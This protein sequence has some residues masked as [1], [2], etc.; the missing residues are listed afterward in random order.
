MADGKRKAAMSSSYTKEG[1]HIPIDE[2]RDIISNVIYGIPG[3][4][5]KYTKSVSPVAEHRLVKDGQGKHLPIY[6]LDKP[7]IRDINRM[8]RYYGGYSPSLDA[9]FLNPALSNRSGKSVDELSELRKTVGHEAF[10]AIQNYNPDL[11]HALHFKASKTEPEDLGRKQYFNFWEA[12]QS[13]DP[14]TSPIGN[15]L[16]RATVE[17]PA[18]ILSNTTPSFY[19]EQ[20][21]D[22]IDKPLSGTVRESGIKGF[23]PKKI[24]TYVGDPNAVAAAQRL[25]YS[26]LPYEAQ[27]VMMP[28][29]LPVKTKEVTIPPEEPSAPLSMSDAYNKF[30][31]IIGLGSK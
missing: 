6:E 30:M 8:P 28:F 22:L 27:K 10:H 13:V 26:E 15:K 12:Y 4:L 5:E 24:D 23:F 21:R 11:T 16:L 14:S 17:T 2:L 19:A 20:A 7:T 9:V 31:S 1:R 3:A 25:L 29:Q 18:Y